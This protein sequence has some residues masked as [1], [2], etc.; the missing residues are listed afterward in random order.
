MNLD[1][2]SPTASVVG[3]PGRAL[4]ARSDE[5]LVDIL[6]CGS[7]GRRGRSVIGHSYSTST[8]VLGAVTVIYFFFFCMTQ[9]CMQS[10]AIRQPEVKLS[11]MVLELSRILTLVHNIR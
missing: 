1:P 3:Q 10:H 5:L 7:L 4:S 8:R 6:A 2:S 11:T 9:L